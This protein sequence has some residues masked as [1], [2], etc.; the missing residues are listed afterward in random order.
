MTGEEGP[1]RQS[2][3]EKS[4][5]AGSQVVRIPGLQA[6]P[7]D[8]GT[9]IDAVR[10]HAFRPL[11]PASRRV[12]PRLL[13][14]VDGQVEQPIAVIHRLDAAPRR[15]VS[16]EDFGSLSQVANEVNQAHP[17]SDQESVERVPGPS[18]KASPSP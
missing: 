12:L 14:P 16:L 10:V 2:K 5:V 13:P 9:S 8:D 7:L 6:R 4:A 17:A 15:P 3:L 18:T 11:W 1:F